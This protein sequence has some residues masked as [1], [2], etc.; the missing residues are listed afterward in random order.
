SV[1]QSAGNRFCWSFTGPTALHVTVSAFSYSISHL[2]SLSMAFRACIEQFSLWHDS[3]DRFPADWHTEN[4][5]P[6]HA[7]AP[8][9]LPR[10]QE[11]PRTIQAQ[12]ESP[13]DERGHRP[14]DRVIH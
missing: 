14:E 8:P 1:C 4:T 5:R 6:I 3:A 11:Q 10:D 2:N 7:V 12:T 13:N 9:D